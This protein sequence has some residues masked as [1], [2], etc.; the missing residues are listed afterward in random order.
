[1][2]VSVKLE[3]FTFLEWPGDP[4]VRSVNIKCQCSISPG[5]TLCST[6]VCLSRDCFSHWPA[7]RL[8]WLFP[9]RHAEQGLDTGS[10]CVAVPRPPVKLRLTTSGVTLVE[11]RT[12]L[13]SIYLQSQLVKVCKMGS[14]DGRLVVI[15]YKLEE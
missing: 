15:N 1:M 5:W 4:R 10:R 12:E 11:L 7:M 9:S 3:L 8:W 14:G 2:Q 13:C 6:L